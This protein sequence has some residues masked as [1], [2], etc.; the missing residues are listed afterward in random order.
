MKDNNLKLDPPL[1][2][3]LNYAIKAL[4][5]SRKITKNIDSSK[6]TIKNDGSLLT[7]FDLKVEK[8]IFNIL[9]NSEADI[10]T[11][12]VLGRQNNKEFC[13][14]VD[15]IDGTTSFSRGIPL[16]GTI[17]GLTQK[18][19][20][21]MGF[22]EL[23]KF[24]DRFISVKNY[25][26][27]KNDV[28]VNASKCI[29][30]SKAMISYGSPQR[31]IKEDMIEQLHI[32]DNKA[33]DSRGFSDC[34][35]YSLVFDGSI[36]LFIEVDLNSWETIALESLSLESGAGFAESKSKNEKK[37]II[38]GSKSLVEQAIDVFGGDWKIK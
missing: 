29:D 33:W 20:P 7:E 37:N 36:D 10:I 23:P 15:P 35:G 27:Y 32:L 3:F 1:N 18:E 12:E 25:G 14:F 31:F 26:C 30:L 34:F 21:I 13:W 4:D 38:F 24:S 5:V 9:K 8:E 2:S 28:K 6:S 17:I 16:F 22:I 11:E 19:Q